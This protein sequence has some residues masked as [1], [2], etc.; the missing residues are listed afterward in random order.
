MDKLTHKTSLFIYGI[1]LGCLGPDGS[2]CKSW[3]PSHLEGGLTH[4]VTTI[5]TQKVLELR[6]SAFEISVENY[7]KR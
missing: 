4:R 1:N 6:Q 2:S 5:G 7:Y 3:K